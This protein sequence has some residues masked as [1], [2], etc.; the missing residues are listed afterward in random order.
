MSNTAYFGNSADNILG[1]V[2]GRFFY[3]LRRTD[4]GELFITKIDQ[5]DPTATIQVNSPGDPEK[6]YKEFEQG[7]DFFE[8]RDQNHEYVYENLTYEQ[9]RW[10]ERHLFYYVNAEGEL[11][12]R[13]NR[14]YTYPTGVSSDGDSNYNPKHF[15]V[16][17]ATGTTGYGTGNRYYLNDIVTPTLNLFEGQTYT[18]GQANATNN[19]H[20]LRFSTTP[21]GTHG[22][23]VEY[24]TGVT[25][26]STAGL[27]GAY[28]KIQI[29]V[30]S[31]TL[32]YYCVNH[33]GMGGQINTL[34]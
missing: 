34:T 9:L 4:D 7:V 15:K 21:N 29:P 13:F 24:T 10:D 17:V 8:G 5:M 1:G 32:Y 31:P 19:T 28:V 12:V 2:D 11:V 14:P 30:N 33:P 16:T 25:K 18:F 20:P 27:E 23:G 3:G 22:G 6:N 26:I